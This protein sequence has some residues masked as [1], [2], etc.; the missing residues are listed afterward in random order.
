MNVVQKAI[1][2]NVCHNK[3]NAYDFIMYSFYWD[4][5]RQI[6]WSAVHSKWTRHLNKIHNG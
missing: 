4:N 3:K 6:N 1:V 2:K 5:D